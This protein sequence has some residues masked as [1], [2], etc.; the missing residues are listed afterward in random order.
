MRNIFFTS[1]VILFHHNLVVTFTNAFASNLIVTTMGCMTDLSTEEVIMNNEVKAVADSD[2]PKMHLVVLDENSNHMESP[3]HYNTEELSLAFVNPYTKEEF[4]EDIQFVMEVDG[5]ASFID[6]GTIGCD[7]DKRVAARLLDDD[8]KVVL[9]INDVTATIKVWAGWATGQN[10]VRLTPELILEPAPQSAEKVEK[11]NSAESNSK[12]EA[13][14]R[15]LENNKN[16]PPPKEKELP[17]PDANI[18]KPNLLKK[19]EIPEELDNRDPQGRPGHHNTKQKIVHRESESSAGG[20]GGGAGGAA[21]RD[22]MAQ[23][24]KEQALDLAATAEK[25]KKPSRNKAPPTSAD[26]GDDDQ[27]RDRQ[28]A[29]DRK[30]RESD[31]RMKQHRSKLEAQMRKNFGDTSSDLN[32]TSHLLG[33]LFFVICLAGFFV[34]FGKKRDKGRRDL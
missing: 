21:H 7:G 10:A 28:A 16:T 22:I 12:A 30:R 32:M 4:S 17:T 13:A 26:V 8:G 23:R 6:G 33:C 31:E 25:I 24:A 19:K 18:L 5:P 20:G 2:F 1:A 11:E 3:Y 9:K 27:S 34:I 15:N 14:E 29:L